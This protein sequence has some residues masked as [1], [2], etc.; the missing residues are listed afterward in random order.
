MCSLFDW[1]LELPLPAAIR[2][3]GP[4][5]RQEF[6]WRRFMPQL[7]EN[8]VVHFYWVGKQFV[9]TDSKILSFNNDF[10]YNPKCLMVLKSAFWKSALNFLLIFVSFVTRS[11]NKFWLGTAVKHGR[12]HQ[13]TNQIRKLFRVFADICFQTSFARQKHLVTFSLPRSFRLILHHPRINTL[14]GFSVFLMF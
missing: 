5:P 14:Q 1:V 3:F 8:I 12:S 9:M 13:G 11:S 10:E 4:V 2:L 6:I 7:Y